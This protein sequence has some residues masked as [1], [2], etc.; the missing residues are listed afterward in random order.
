MTE[1]ASLLKLGENGNGIRSRWYP[2][3]LKR[4]IEIIAQHRDKIAFLRQD[5]IA[6]IRANAGDRNVAF[7][8]DPP[9]MIAGQRL[10]RHSEVDHRELFAA[11]ASVSG[12]LLLTYDNTPEARSLAQEFGFSTKQIK[13]RTTHHSVKVELLISRTFSWLDQSELV[14]KS[15]NT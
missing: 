14:K 8:V 6:Y 11:A 2:E 9:Y 1:D 10:Y 3:T 12:N 15:N 4:R 7:F 13:M 5:G